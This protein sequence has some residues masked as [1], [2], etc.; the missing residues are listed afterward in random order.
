M[1]YAI[2]YRLIDGFPQE[3]KIEC[4]RLEEAQLVWD[5]MHYLRNY[6]IMVSRRPR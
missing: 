1:K 3:F 4:E 2:I 5:S 6:Y